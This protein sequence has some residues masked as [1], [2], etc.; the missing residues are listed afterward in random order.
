[1]RETEGGG[2]DESGAPRRVDGHAARHD[3]R[4]GYE[5]YTGCLHSRTR[6]HYAAAPWQ[7]TTPKIERKVRHVTYLIV[8]QCG[9]VYA[10]ERLSL[11]EASSCWDPETR[12]SPLGSGMNADTAAPSSKAPPPVPRTLV[13]L[14]PLGTHAR[15]REIAALHF[16]S[17]MPN[18]LR[19]EGTDGIIKD[20]C[21]F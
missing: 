2:G 1:M 20:P 11:V 18:G 17:S 8:R 13:V 19:N 15:T 12:S 10:R 6:H 14:N 16:A 5:H 3:Y 9:F 21:R 4:V 7:R